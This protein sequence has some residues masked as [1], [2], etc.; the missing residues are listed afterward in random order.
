MVQNDISSSYAHTSLNWLFQPLY[1]KNNILHSNRCRKKQKQNSYRKHHKYS[2][3]WNLSN[4]LWMHWTW[5]WTY[6]KSMFCA[7][8]CSFS[9]VGILC[10]SVCVCVYVRSKPRFY[11]IS[12][13]LRIIITKISTHNKNHNSLNNTLNSM[14]H[15]VVC[16]V[17]TDQRNGSISTN[18]RTNNQNTWNTNVIPFVYTH[19]NQCDECMWVFVCTS[20][21][22]N[23]NERELCVCVSARAFVL[24]SVHLYVLLF[25]FFC[26]MHVCQT[27]EPMFS[28]SKWLRVI[29]RASS[30]SVSS[31]FLRTA[32]LFVYRTIQNRLFRYFMVMNVFEMNIFWAWI[33]FSWI[34]LAEFFSADIFWIKIFCSIF[35][36]LIF[37]ENF[38]LGFFPLTFLF[39]FLSKLFCL[40]FFPKVKK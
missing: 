16:S 25:F 38:L 40:I 13:E 1:H 22:A 26:L 17:G 33:C 4:G 29:L 19:L 24:T 32:M 15:N 35:F 28:N 10:V 3:N 30:D 7:M 12:G 14:E 31:L 20:A 5:T 18:L 23:V 39:D 21:C 9:L 36:L 8:Q 11:L 27:N 34:F 2:I 6:Q 37:F